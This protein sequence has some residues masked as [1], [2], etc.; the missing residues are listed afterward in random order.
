MFA[1]CGNNPIILRDMGGMASAIAYGDDFDIFSDPT[2]DPLSGGGGIGVIIFV[3]PAPLSPAENSAKSDAI[4]L[5]DDSSNKIYTVY[6]LYA[7]NGSPDDIVYVGR[8]KTANMGSRMAYH[9]TQRRRLSFYISDL[10]WTQCRGLE[11]VGMIFFHTINRNNPMNNQIRGVGPRNSSRTLY[12][13]AAKAFW[14]TFGSNY[15]GVMPYSYWAN[16]TE[17]EFLNGPMP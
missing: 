10:T 5:Q 13:S 2:D 15:G 7:A 6:F 16:W 8:V 9:R 12:F 4:R 17:N 11:Q 1:Y 14:D 3:S